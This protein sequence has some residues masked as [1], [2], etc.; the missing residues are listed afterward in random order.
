MSEAD[1]AMDR[2][3]AGYEAC[4]VELHTSRRHYFQAKAITENCGRSHE[5]MALIWFWVMAHDK[6]ALRALERRWR[7]DPES[8]WDD[9][10]DISDT[11][12]IPPGSPKSIE[13]A[14]AVNAALDDI[15]GAQ[16]EFQPG[17]GGDGSP[18]K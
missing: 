4:G 13:V 2:A 14:E 17:E 7:R 3:G 18:G 15:I 9:I 8:V 5:E 12:D 1:K 6:D 10:A 16:V 11:Y